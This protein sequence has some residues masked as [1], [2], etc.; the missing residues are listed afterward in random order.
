MGALLQDHSNHLA[1]CCYLAYYVEKILI[2]R[3]ANMVILK[4][5]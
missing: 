3:M 5:Q 2:L 1:L 4:E